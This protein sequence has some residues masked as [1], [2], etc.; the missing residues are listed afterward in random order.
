MSSLR[1]FPTAPSRRGGDVIDVGE[2]MR[3]VVKVV[4]TQWPPGAEAMLSHF[5]FY[6][7]S[8]QYGTFDVEANIGEEKRK[9]DVYAGKFPVEGVIGAADSMPTPFAVQDIDPMRLR[10]ILD[11]AAR[12]LGVDDVDRRELSLTI[13]PGRARTRHG[14]WRGWNTAMQTPRTACFTSCAQVST[15]ARKADGQGSSA[16]RAAASIAARTCSGGCRTPR[17][18]N[19]ATVSCTRRR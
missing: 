8:T 6:T 14:R 13:L 11:D 2:T 4:A 12:R 16:R 18:V 19:R 1:C 10:A 17:S 9:I 7:S 15:S 3:Q 5:R